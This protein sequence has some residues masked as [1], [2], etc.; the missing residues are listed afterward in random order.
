MLG[1]GAAEDD[2]LEG[3]V[4]EDVVEGVLWKVVYWWGGGGGVH[5]G[6][7]WWSGDVGIVSGGRER[8]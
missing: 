8:E 7:G 3:E 2:L 4:G 1:E 6:D 5:G